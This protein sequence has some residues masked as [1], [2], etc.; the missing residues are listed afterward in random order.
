MKKF[1]KSLSLLLAGLLCCAALFAC[2]EEDTAVTTATTTAATTTVATTTAPEDEE[3]TTGDNEVTDTL[4]QDNVFSKVSQRMRELKSYSSQVEMDMSISMMG[5]TMAMEMGVEAIADAEG[6]RYYTKTSASIMGETSTAVNYFDE[7]VYFMDDG[8]EKMVA[9]MTPELMEYLQSDNEGVL[10]LDATYFESFKLYS[11]EDGY[12][13]V[14]SGLKAGSGLL[15]SVLDSEMLEGYQI[16]LSDVEIEMTVTKD[17]CISEMTMHLGMS[18]DLSELPDAEN[19]DI[20][21]GE[22][23]ASMEVTATYGDFDSAADKLVKPDMSDAVKVEA[24]DLLG[25]LF[26]DEE[27]EA[28]TLPV[29]EEGD[30]VDQL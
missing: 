29:T 14:I 21:L 1:T 16:D 12:L 9:D 6:S 8:E 28:E 25:G 26:G 18:M 3:P 13:L 20:P 23:S 7:E 17:Y 27:D 2:D 19:S 5:M 11:S 15:D 10:E 22:V 24:E 4:T 30:I